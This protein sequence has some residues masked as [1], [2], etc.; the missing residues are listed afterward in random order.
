MDDS[1][2]DLGV[3]GF[4]LVG[5]KPPKSLGE[6]FVRLL[7]VLIVVGILYLIG[8]AMLQSFIDGFMP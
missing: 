6:F 3:L 5:P 7:I 2:S 8:R 4:F 1:K